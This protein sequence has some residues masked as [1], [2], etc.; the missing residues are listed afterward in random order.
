MKILTILIILITVYGCKEKE[1][2]PLPS[3]CLEIVKSSV[4]EDSDI[5]DSSASVKGNEVTLVL[6]MS[7]T[8]TQK[9]AQQ[10]G[11]NFLRLTKSLCQ[12]S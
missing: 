1:L 9:R 3:G 12:V 4:Q 6:I 7:E 8:T 10:Q 5:L 2:T 11:D